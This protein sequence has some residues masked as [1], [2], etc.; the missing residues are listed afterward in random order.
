MI[1]IVPY[2]PRW[3]LEFTR[4]AQPCLKHLARL[5]FASTISARQQFQG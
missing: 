3:P 1:I 5:L 2:D 4:L